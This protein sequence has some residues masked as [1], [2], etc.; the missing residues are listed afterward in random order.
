MYGHLL[1]ATTKILVFLGS[2]Q[3][4][5][6]KAVQASYGHPFLEEIQGKFN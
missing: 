1:Q 3:R 6:Q 5:S 2:R 4:F